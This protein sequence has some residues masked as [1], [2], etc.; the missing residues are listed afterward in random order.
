VNQNLNF[1]Q[2]SRSLSLL[3]EEEQKAVLKY[4][5]VKDAKMSLGSSLLK[6]F[7]I[8]KLCGAAWSEVILSRAVNGKPCYVPKI[9]G[10]RS[11]EFNVSH[12]AGIVTIVACICAEGEVSLGTDIVCVNER[13]DY[14]R[15]EKEGFFSWVD[16]H[17]DVFAPRETQFLKVDTTQLA[18]PLP[19]GLQIAGYAR[20]AIS[21]C[22]YRSQ[23]ITW[24]DAAGEAREIDASVVIEAKLRRFYAIWCL[25]EAYVKMTGEAL[26][27]KWLQELEFR[28]YKTPPAAKEKEVFTNTNLEPGEV[29]TDIE[30]YFK[31]KMVKDVA[32][33][34]RAFGTDFIMGS[35]ARFRDGDTSRMVFSGFTQLD[36]EE[37]IFAIA[38]AG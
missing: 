17:S 27:A 12:Q 30:V 6:R 23:R 25:R 1:K 2:A 26:L 21:R 3:P 32:M 38:E 36:L 35:A 9:A 31:G 18:L 15:I 20:D 8:A 22:Q 13:D 5:H 19:E 29:I 28:R 24:K 10:S 37:D 4:Y 34:M 14:A 16:M 7:A 33:E 11:I